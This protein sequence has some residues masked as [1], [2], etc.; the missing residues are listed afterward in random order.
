MTLFAGMPS[1]SLEER[2]IS[3]G[4]TVLLTAWLVTRLAN[5]D[6][7]ILRM[8]CGIGVAVALVMTL[9][10]RES[11]LDFVHWQRNGLTSGLIGFI[12]GVIAGTLPL[13][14]SEILDASLQG[15]QDG[16]RREA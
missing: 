2:L 10:V 12:A 13:P 7:M 11:Y 5:A 9:W 8:S 4:L 3:A 6:R 1:I 14:R 16:E 15:L